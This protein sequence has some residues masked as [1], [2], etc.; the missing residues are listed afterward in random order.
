[1]GQYQFPVTGG[2]D[3][4]QFVDTLSDDASNVATHATATITTRVYVQVHNRGILP[5]N[6]VRVMLLLANASTGLPALP[7]GYWI[8]VQT[9][10]P[11]NTANWRTV[12]IVTLNDVRV[13]APKV[14]AFDLTSNMLPPPANLSGNQH[15]C[16][17]ALLHHP[18]DQYT[19]MITNTD[20][21]SVAERKAAHKNLTVVQF[22]GTLPAPPPTVIPFRIH[23][24][25]LEQEILTGIR[26]RLSG[27][28]GL[29]RLYIPPLRTTQPLEEIAHGLN[30]DHDF[31]TFKEWADEHIQNIRENLESDNPYDR[32]WSLQRIEDIERSFE[33][34]R[35]FRIE[36]GT[37]EAQLQ[38]IQMDPDSYHTFFLVLD[39]PQNGEMGQN[40]SI[41]ILQTNEE[42]QDIA[43]GLTLRVELVEEPEIEKYGLELWQQ[44]WIFG[45]AVFRARLYDPAGNL[46]RPNGGAAMQLLVLESNRWYEVKM[47]WHN[48]WNSFYYFR[49]SLSVSQVIATGFFNGAKVVEAHLSVPEVEARSEKPKRRKVKAA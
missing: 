19:S 8:N 47:L 21:N 18:D 49:R 22:T 41:D 13:G 38:G 1:M 37:E 3:F 45:Y 14:A 33:D 7:S 48:G 29:G 31:D 39:R 15:H 42:Q 20:D 35:M 34:G 26:L 30:I 23:N 27:Y 44:R 6:G 16:V 9:G 4:H 24:A 28:P 2:I 12:G 43:G 46:L 17:L 5:A 32:E 36:A 25:E 10:M 40:Y 11:I